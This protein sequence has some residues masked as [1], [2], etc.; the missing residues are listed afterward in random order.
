[1][2]CYFLPCSKVNQLYMYMRLS[3][4][5]PMLC[6]ILKG[7]VV[8]ISKLSAYRLH[9]CLITILPNILSLFSCVYELY[10]CIYMHICK[11]LLSVRN[12]LHLLYFCICKVINYSVGNILKTLT[13]VYRH[14]NFLPKAPHLVKCTQLPNSHG[15]SFVSSKLL[16]DFRITLSLFPNSKHLQSSVI[17]K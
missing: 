15:S 16:T 10:A 5:F 1:M 13:T 9:V 4:S 2:L 12:F 17:P 14:P 8:E 11:M 7:G 3:D 6:I